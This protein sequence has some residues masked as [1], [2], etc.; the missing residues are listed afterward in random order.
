LDE[1]IIDKLEK[2]DVI[3]SLFSVQM[4]YEQGHMIMGEED[5]WGYYEKAEYKL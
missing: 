4:K 3:Q 5:G 2:F 1:V